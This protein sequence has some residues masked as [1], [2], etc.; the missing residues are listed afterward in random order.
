M[1]RGLAEIPVKSRSLTLIFGTPTLTLQAVEKGDWLRRKLFFLA[2]QAHQ[3]V[4]V[5]FFDALVDGPC[6]K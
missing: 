5:P 4:P 3:P 2:I 1:D 6:R